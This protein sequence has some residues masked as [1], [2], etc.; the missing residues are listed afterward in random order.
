MDHVNKPS[1]P[2]EIANYDCSQLTD[3]GKT[4][5]NSVYDDTV[6]KWV[7]NKRCL[8]HKCKR[9]NKYEIHYGTSINVGK[10]VG[11]CKSNKRCSPNTHDIINVGS[12]TNRVFVIK[13]CDCDDCSVEPLTTTIEV[14]VSKCSGNCNTYQYDKTC[15]A[16]ISDQFSTINGMEPSNPSSALLSGILS[17]CSAGIQNGFDVFVNDRCFGHTF[18]NCLNKGECPLK[19]AI[20]QICLRAANVPLTNTDSLILGINGASIWGISLPNLNG[21]TW[22][23]GD[24]LCATLNLGNLPNGGATILNNIQSVGH[25]DVVVQDDTAVD[26]VRLGIHYEQCKVCIPKITT[27]GTYYSSSG[28]SDYVNS[29]HCDCV[30]GGECHRE[31]H[32]VSYFEGTTFETNINVGQCVGK[33]PEFTKCRGNDIDH[34]TIKAPEG[35]RVI[36]I[37]NSCKCSNFIWNPNGYIIKE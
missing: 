35:S 31:N 24:Q 27:I 2:L 17:S 6:C 8:A 28:I 26:Y 25:L 16:G 12:D 7:S 34:I 21:G 20:L 30:E 1:F 9:V 15:V 14:P 22:N 3:F 18:I 4:R 10:C 19:S 33:C 37:I 5:C 23:P 29:E 32:H 11:Q 13:N 36:N